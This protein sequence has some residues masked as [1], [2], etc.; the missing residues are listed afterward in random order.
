RDERQL[1]KAV[2]KN[3][4]TTACKLVKSLEELNIIA[5][6][7]TIRRTLHSKNV[8]GRKAVNQDNAPCHKA[9]VANRW[10]EE[11]RVIVLPWPA[12]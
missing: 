3:T 4:K 11:N 5:S 2:K 12:Q 9:A 1:T 8:Y 6:E 7:K 10:K